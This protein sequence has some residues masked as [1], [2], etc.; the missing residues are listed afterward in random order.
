MGHRSR[1]FLLVG[2]ARN[3]PHRDRGVP[4]W[5]AMNGSTGALRAYLD[6][7]GSG[8]LPAGAE[9]AGRELDEVLGDLGAVLTEAMWVRRPRRP[10]EG[11]TSS[12][13]ATSSGLTVDL[14]D[15]CAACR[16]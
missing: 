16:S 9:G 8:V 2:R 3:H 6:L 11:S 12:S 10:R 4:T 15:P 7:E 1:E 14:R 5:L 13:A